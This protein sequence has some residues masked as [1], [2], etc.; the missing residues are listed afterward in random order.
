[1]L[2]LNPGQKLNR[3]A[4]DLEQ[5]GACA[6]L[7]I[8]IAN[9]ANVERRYGAAAHH[10]T[11]SKL[12][13][14]VSELAKEFT[15][16]GQVLVTEDRGADA[17]LAFLFRPRSDRAFY[18]EQ[19]PQLTVQLSEQLS[20][21]GKEAVY[22]YHRDPLSL[23]V[24]LTVLL[25]NPNVKPE[26]QIR[27]GMEIARRDAQLEADL[28]ARTRNRELLELILRG[29]LGTRFEPIVSLRGSEVIGYEA[30]ARGRADSELRTP[31]QLFQQAGEC[32]LTYE[33]D[34]LCRRAAL[35]RV[36]CLPPGKK[37]FLNCLPTSIGDPSLRDEGLVKTL[38]NYQLRP[39]DVVLEISEQ[40]SI[41]NF[42]IFREMR[43]SWRELGLQIAID[44][45]GAGYA[46][47]E[48][49]MEI[50][51]DFLKADMRLV[52]GID[53]DPPRQE[54]LR[55]LNAVARRIGAAVIAEGI[56][57]QEELRV[58]RQLGVPYGQ[59]YY[60]GHGLSCEGDEAG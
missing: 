41:E 28:R 11:V 2:S 50:T 35:E 51:P 55:A 42:A 43:D 4:G 14:L 47:L 7:L 17:L 21:R 19:L 27:E 60:F 16:G 33:L 23:P 30:L 56:E 34:C 54:V 39:G 57:T 1:M 49:I 58:L 26:R 46:S 52:R 5:S 13:S 32:G 45:A 18:D 53:T 20:R 24:G 48:A 38:E 3:I 12:L 6:L 36:H 8:D 22:P 15:T 40:E 37:L 31:A 25:H 9:L 44:D 29:E 10:Q 59:G